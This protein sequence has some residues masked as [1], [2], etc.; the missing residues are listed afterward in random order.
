MGNLGGFGIQALSAM[1]LPLLVVCEELEE[2]KEEDE[3]R[4]EVVIA[5][6]FIACEAGCEQEDVGW[7]CD[8]EEKEL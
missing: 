4:E 7:C 3:F 1:E 2:D 8:G 5:A 6:E